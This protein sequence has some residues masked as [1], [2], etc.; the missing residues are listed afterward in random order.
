MLI[1]EA[2]GRQITCQMLEA[3]NEE[4]FKKHGKMQPTKH[5]PAKNEWE[6]L[7]E[8]WCCSFSVETV[9]S[10]EQMKYIYTPDLADITPT[11]NLKI[12]KII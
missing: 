5:L 3:A 10:E 12:I 9:G 1:E 11:P 4:R 6:Y 8:L 2:V 7:A